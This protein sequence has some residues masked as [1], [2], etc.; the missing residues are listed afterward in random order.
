MEFAIAAHGTRGDI[1]PCAALALELSRRG[2]AIRM[3]VPPN[4]LGFVESAG[5]P[6]IAYGPDSQQQLDNEFFKGFWKIQNPLALIR[7]GREYLAQGWA[8]MSATLVDLAEGAD[9]LITATT[10]QE[11]AANVAEYYDIPSGALHYFPLRANGQISFPGLPLPAPLTRS[12]TSAIWSLHWQMTRDADN[13]Q[14]RELGLSEARVSSCQR[15]M[16]R[17]AL[18]VQAYDALCFPG[19]VREWADARPFVGTLTLKLATEADDDVLAWAA[20]G[21]API[22][23]GFGSMPVDNAE[24]TIAMI[25]RVC[26]QL[27]ER[28][29]ICAPGSAGRRLSGVANDVVKVV[30]EVNHSAVFPSCKA[31][32]HHGGAGTTAAGMRAGVP[33]LILWVGADQ[34]IWAAAVKRLGVGNSR[35]FSNTTDASL[36]AD[37]RR[38]LV[39]SWGVSARAL[40]AQLTTPQESVAAAADLMERRAC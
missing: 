8:E 13:H 6:A 2:H 30:G 38:I 25:G 11:V 16:R 27:G 1:E 32:V 29:L 18:E 15:G 24:D 23:F 26:A 40:A 4:L 3:A 37:L 14:R 34:P 5:L 39:P 33:T 31:V 28:A 9:L 20:H 35:R 12:A 22:Y 17:G 21:T 19:L 10:Y 7:A 36:E